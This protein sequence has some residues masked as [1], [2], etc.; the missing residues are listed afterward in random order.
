MKQNRHQHSAQR[1]KILDIP[2]RKKGD[3]PCI[4]LQGMYWSIG[5]AWITNQN[6]Y[7]KK[8]R[9]GK[10]KRYRQEAFILELT[11]KSAKSFLFDGL[12]SLLDHR[13]C[14]FSL[15]ISPSNFL[16]ALGGFQPGRII[17][18]G[19]GGRSE[20]GLGLGLSRAW[21][22]IYGKCVKNKGNLAGYINMGF[23]T[24]KYQHHIS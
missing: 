14:H 23:W 15:W 19:F 21:V 3:P 4:Q 17:C 9:R 12:Q 13:C 18:I 7:I 22:K 2:I 6:R 5:C 8:L 24:L 20:Y 16:F 11:Q 10:G 1:N